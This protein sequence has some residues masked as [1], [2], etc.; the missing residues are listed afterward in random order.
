MGHPGALPRHVRT[1]RDPSEARAHIHGPPA[2]VKV[3]EGM[4]ILASNSTRLVRVAVL[5]IRCGRRYDDRQELRDAHSAGGPFDLVFSVQA[6]HELRH[7]RHA[8]RL[9]A[10]IRALLSPGAEFVVCDHL[11]ELGPTPRHRRLYMSTTENLA[12]LANAGFSD[13]KLVWNEHE[14]ALYRARA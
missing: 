14:M 4:A 3:Y 6:V 1:S 8:P 5:P 13:A 10:Q 11:P 7:K 2:V 9:Y 12:A